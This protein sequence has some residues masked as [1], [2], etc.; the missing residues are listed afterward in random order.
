MVKN[1]VFVNNKVEN[2]TITKFEGSKG[3]S[4]GLQYKFSAKLKDGPL[5][6]LCRAQFSP[7]PAVV[8]DRTAHDLTRKAQTVANPRPTTYK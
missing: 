3:L 8:R 4:S 2:R 6:C 5:F 7:F 1:P